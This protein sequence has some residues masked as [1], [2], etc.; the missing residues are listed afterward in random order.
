MPASISS[1]LPPGT[2]SGRSRLWLR[3]R[4][5]EPLDQALA[6]RHGHSAGRLVL[7]AGGVVACDGRALHPAARER[8][9]RPVRWVTRVGLGY[10]LPADEGAY[11]NA[12]EDHL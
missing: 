9:N 2:T 6:H 5:D 10:R 3:E 7:G 1:T 12:L 11:R 4:H 8:A